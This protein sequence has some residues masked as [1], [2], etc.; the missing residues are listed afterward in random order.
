[1][2]D[3][4]PEPDLEVEELGPTWSSPLPDFSQAAINRRLR[5][6][7]FD[8]TI[9]INP[10]EHKVDLEPDT[11]LVQ[12]AVMYRGQPLAAADLGVDP[13][14]CLNLWSYICN[15]LT[16]ATVDFYGPVQRLPGEPN[17]RLG[18]WGPRPDLLESGLAES[19]CGIAVV[20]GIATWTIGARPLGSDDDYLEQLAEATTRSL[21]YWVLVAQ[22]QQARRD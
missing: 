15:R 11:D 2:S 12:L 8:F 19:D 1:M 7:G 14:V 13:S 4:D 3:S 20:I 6:G 5:I 9:L 21:A 17:P 18:C 10:V 16:E 22:R